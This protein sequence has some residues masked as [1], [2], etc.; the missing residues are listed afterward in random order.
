MLKVPTMSGV[1]WRESPRTK[2]WHAFWGNQETAEN[3][4][5]PLCRPG[6]I[7]VGKVLTAPGG[8]LVCR[9]CLKVIAR[10]QGLT[11]TEA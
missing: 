8:W 2:R 11:S 10:E 1:V 5:I 9:I 4:A 7:E 6:P 3:H